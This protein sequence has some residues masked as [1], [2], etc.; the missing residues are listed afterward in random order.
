MDNKTDSRAGTTTGRSLDFP[1]SV[2]LGER[3]AIDRSLRPGC[4]VRKYRV[5]VF[6]TRVNADPCRVTA[7]TAGLRR[8]QSDYRAH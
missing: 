7:Q 8:H 4:L 5:D 1:R 2:L 6:Y 3:S